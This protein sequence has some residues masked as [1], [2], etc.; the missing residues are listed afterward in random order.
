MEAD[1]QHS[2]MP[3]SVRWLQNIG[4][5]IWPGKQLKNFPQKIMQTL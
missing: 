5:A 1:N 4:G 2:F 3:L